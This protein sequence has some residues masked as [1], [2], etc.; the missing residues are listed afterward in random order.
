MIF[1]NNSYEN[2]WNN[3]V[4]T[5]GGILAGFLGDQFARLGYESFANWNGYHFPVLL[6]TQMW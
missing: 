2:I 6:F 1:W 5:P 4:W 3:T